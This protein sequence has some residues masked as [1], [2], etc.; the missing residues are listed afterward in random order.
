[1]PVCVLQ[2]NLNIATT[3]KT[4]KDNHTPKRRKKYGTQKMKNILQHLFCSA[5]DQT[6][7]WSNI[8]ETYYGIVTLE[9]RWKVKI[10]LDKR[11]LFDRGFYAIQIFV[12]CSM[13]NCELWNVVDF[14][15]QRNL[16]KQKTGNKS[17]IENS[18]FQRLE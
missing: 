16:V 8:K 10:V 12:K 15:K 7:C 17:K 5:V 2:K 3:I 18:I 11:V 1:M 14:Q 4:S 9:F 6:M 13:F